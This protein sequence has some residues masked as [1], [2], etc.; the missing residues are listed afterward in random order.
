MAETHPLDILSISDDRA[1]VRNQALG[2]C[3]EVGRLLGGAVRELVVPRR[4]GK[5]FVLIGRR[6]FSAAQNLTNELDNYLPVIFVGEPTGEN[7]N[8]MGD[9]RPVTL[10]RSGLTFYLS[11][12]WWQD[13]PQWLK[14]PNGMK[15]R[16]KIRVVS[17]MS[18]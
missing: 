16:L 15:A 5:L 1:G 11:W 10:P 3:E 4:E 8:F 17:A 7:I 9:N 2:L 12:A 13:K 18:A 6:T 14:R